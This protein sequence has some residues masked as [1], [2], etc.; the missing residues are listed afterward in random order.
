MDENL[1]GDNQLKSGKSNLKHG[2]FRNSK[3]LL[4]IDQ[5]YTQKQSGRE[6]EL[7]ETY[8][9]ISK[10]SNRAA[11]LIGQLQ[12]NYREKNGINEGLQR[13]KKY[14]LEDFD[15]YKHARNKAEMERNIKQLRHR[16]YK[17]D[18]ANRLLDKY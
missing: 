5:K 4:T 6:S 12:H 11:D 15:D 8:A 16:I 17:D 1:L 14:T 9:D 10:V 18:R 2:S 13:Y 7:D 3:Y